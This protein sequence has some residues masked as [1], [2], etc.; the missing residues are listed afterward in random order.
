MNPTRNIQA[1]LYGKYFAD[2]VRISVGMI[3]PAVIFSYLGNLHIGVTISVGA[4]VIALSDTHGPINH[5]RNGMLACAAV[6]LLSATITN[7][8][9][10][11]DLLLGIAIVVLSFLFAMMAVF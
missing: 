7:L 9:D 1:F 2:G 6:A 5:R 3:T 4:M 10:H 11:N 8:M